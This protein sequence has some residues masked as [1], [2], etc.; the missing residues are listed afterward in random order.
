[1][2]ILLPLSLPAGWPDLRQRREAE[3][4]L[5]REGHAPEL[6][7]ANLDDIRRVNELGGGVRV[8]L[9]RL[10]SLLRQIPAGQPVTI[11]DLGTGSADIPVAVA[12]WLRRRDRA[13]RIVGSDLSDE[14][15]AVAAAAVGERSEIRLANIN[16][17]DTGLAEGSFHIVLCSLMLHHLERAAGVRLLQEMARVCSVGFILNDIARGWPGYAVAWAASRV[18]TCNPLTRHDMPLSVERAWTPGELR[19]MLADAGLPRA[20]VSTHPLFRMA[21][22]YEKAGYRP[23]PVR[24]AA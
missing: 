23:T 16:A 24:S 7:A 20:H 14:V 11:L 22:V 10:P 15:L 6:L 5:D 8:V 2:P 13:C 3:E 4:L 18:A 12:D 21:A 1:M 17:V 9:G 19:E